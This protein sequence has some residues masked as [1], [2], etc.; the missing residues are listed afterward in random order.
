M[1]DDPGLELFLQTHID[2]D[3]SAI[4]SRGHEKHFKFSFPSMPGT[5]V[6][7]DYRQLPSLFKYSDIWCSCILNKY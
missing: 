5:V 7:I 6:T 4:G 2:L 1:F 3:F